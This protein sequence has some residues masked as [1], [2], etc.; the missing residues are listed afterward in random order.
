[1]QESERIV[2]QLQRAYDGN[3]WYGPPLRGLLAD[4]TAAEAAKRPLPAAHSVWE[5][6]LHL[7]GWVETIRIRLATGRPEQPAEGDWP[8]A[9]AT[10][11]AAWARARNTLEERHAALVRAVAALDDAQ[12]AAC[13]GGAHEPSGGE[14]AY[15]TLHG[16]VQHNAYHAGQIAMLKRALRSA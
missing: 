6:V 16:L 11:E 14:S 7:S 8:A 4:L 15:T 3:A 10:D 9:G 5:I 1:V 13:I 12:L 2:D